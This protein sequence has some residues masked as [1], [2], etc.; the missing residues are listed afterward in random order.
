[1]WTHLSIWTISDS[2]ISTFEIQMAFQDYLRTL[3]QLAT[4]AHESGWICEMPSLRDS[5]HVAV[6]GEIKRGKSTFLNALM[7]EKIFP[8]RSSVCTTAVT[9]LQDGP[10]TIEA[11]YRPELN[12]P[13][14][15]RQVGDGENIF[16][17]LQEMVAKPNL[18][19]KKGNPNARDLDAV[20]VS[21]PNRFATDG[22]RLVDT[23]GVND[24]ESWREEITFQFLPQVDAALMLMDPQ[25]PLSKSEMDFLKNRATKSVKDQLLIVVSRCDEVKPEDLEKSVARIRREV[26]PLL[27]NARIFT[28]ASKPA[29]EA[30]QTGQTIPQ[31]WVQF[32]AALDR[33]LHAG[34][35]GALLLSRAKVMHDEVSSVL[36]TTDAHLESLS[37]SDEMERARLEQERMELDRISIGI[38]NLRQRTQGMLSVHR[39]QLLSNLERFLASQRSLLHTLPNNDLS[40]FTS[41]YLRDLQESR[42]SW[43]ERVAS[44]LEISLHQQVAALVGEATQV[45]AFQL[46]SFEIPLAAPTFTAP[47]RDE[48][49]GF[50]PGLLGGIVG[51][52]FGGPLVGAGVAFLTRTLFGSD[53]VSPDTSTFT[54]YRMECDAFLENC[55]VKVRQDV[56]NLLQGLHTEWIPQFFE[57]L[58]SEIDRQSRRVSDTQ[59]DLSQGE[60]ERENKR[61]VL[62][63]QR[64]SLASMLTRTAGLIENLRTAGASST[65]PSSDNNA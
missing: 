44:D 18:L 40:S 47:K 17:C 56:E 52:I 37:R 31:S 11:I 51:T 35:A 10:P 45:R 21:Y 48:S 55:R 5:V 43:I 36:R 34:K 29:L 42:A 16:D 14:D 53:T 64:D 57:P 22:V 1:M 4:E 12:R 15:H 3:G 20:V 24:P 19:G 33:F 62:L 63:A 49:A 60:Q 65:I 6:I 23:P 27:P 39:E 58:Q 28:V 13:S 50:L 30:K 32:E 54:T 41:R 26:E 25:Q 61:Q 7:G 8:S 46:P 59:A 9:F 38:A 2:H